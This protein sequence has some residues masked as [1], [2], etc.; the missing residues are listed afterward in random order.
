VIDAQGGITLGREEGEL[1]ADFTFLGNSITGTAL[2]LLE[3]QHPELL[4][5]LFE[6]S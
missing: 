2:T 1:G 4:S 6:S 3:Q 5:A